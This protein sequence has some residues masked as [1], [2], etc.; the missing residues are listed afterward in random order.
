MKRDPDIETAIL[1]LNSVLSGANVAKARRT[2]GTYLSITF[3]G[4]EPDVSTYLVLS[5]G[6][7]SI[8]GIDGDVSVLDEIPDQLIDAAVMKLV[9]LSVRSV[10]ASNDILDI[11]FSSGATL[12]AET[13]FKAGDSDCDNWYFLLGEASEPL[14]CCDPN[15]KLLTS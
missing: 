9:G 1:R 2:F 13:T 12:R 7:W 15:G 5:S 8:R 3:D 6:N 10:F 14:L 11:I 4:V